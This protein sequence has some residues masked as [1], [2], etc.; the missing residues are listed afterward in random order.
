M[1]SAS[2]REREREEEPLP[3]GHAGGASNGRSARELTD[4]AHLRRAAMSRT[5]DGVSKDGLVVSRWP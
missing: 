2:K 3:H 4:T 1:A 5:P